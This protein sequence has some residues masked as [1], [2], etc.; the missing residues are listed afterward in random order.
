[1][2]MPTI[3]K[4]FVLTLPVLVLLD[5]SWIGVV[6]KGFYRSHLGHLMSGS[7]SWPAAVVFYFVFLG[8]LF[9]FVSVPNMSGSILRLFI[10][11]AL[12]GLVTYGTYDLTNNATL[13]E[14]PII[15]TVVDIAWGMALSGILAALSGSLL[16]W[17]S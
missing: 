12:F 7:V 1:M 3:L 8:G 6:M 11:G 14:W 15:V 9:F 13:K 17:F 10:Y 4:A 5:L 16:N 2:Y